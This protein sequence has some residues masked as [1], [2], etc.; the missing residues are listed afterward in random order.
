MD[1]ITLARTAEEATHATE[2][3]LHDDMTWEASNTQNKYVL[4][5]IVRQKDNNE[6]TEY[7]VQW[8]G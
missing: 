4:E 3:K 6:E 1:H 5:R 2:I 7:L 8:Y